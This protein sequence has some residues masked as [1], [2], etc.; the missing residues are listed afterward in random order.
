MNLTFNP[1]NICNINSQ[2]RGLDKTM[3]HFGLAAR[4]SNQNPETFS[5]RRKA[6]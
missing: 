6:I 2:N 3:R 4:L 5:A 1:I